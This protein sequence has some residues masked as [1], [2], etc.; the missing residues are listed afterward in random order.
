MFSMFKKDPKKELQKEYE[1]LMKEAVERQRN[2]DIEGYS[3][4]S[5]KADEIAKK[6][7]QLTSDS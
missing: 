5:A 4:L 6:L 7:D 1:K 2:G 3:T